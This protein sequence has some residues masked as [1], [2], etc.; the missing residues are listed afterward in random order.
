M[1]CWA[2]LRSTPLLLGAAR[3]APAAAGR[4]L[5]FWRLHQR[6]C[7]AG[8]H[9]VC[10]VYARTFSFSFAIH[11]VAWLVTHHTCAIGMQYNWLLT[12]R[13]AAVLVLAV[14]HALLAFAMAITPLCFQI[15][16]AK[17][18]S[19]AMQHGGG[20]F[21]QHCTMDGRVLTCCSHVQCS[22]LGELALVH[23]CTRC[24]VCSF[25]GPH[26]RLCTVFCKCCCAGQRRSLANIGK[27]NSGKQ[28][29]QLGLA[30]TLYV[31]FGSMRM[32][33]KAFWL[34]ARRE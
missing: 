5:C 26:G 9:R 10:I 25:S 27:L 30:C 33:A 14:I 16:H 18:H 29:L 6:P 31:H 22:Q 12:T 2:G 4:E 21:L 23:A 34:S 7:S 3:H 28:L 19:A 1:Q 20:L 32:I 11:G 13:P 8:M 24:P 15:S 17:R